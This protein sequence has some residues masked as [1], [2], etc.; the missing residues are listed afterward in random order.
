MIK[1]ILFSITSSVLS[2]PFIRTKLR[3]HI[4]T[5]VNKKFEDLKINR[6]GYLNALRNETSRKSFQNICNNK[7]QKSKTIIFYCRTPQGEIPKG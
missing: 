4:L 3:D 7:R 2:V 5:A 6:N 1:Y